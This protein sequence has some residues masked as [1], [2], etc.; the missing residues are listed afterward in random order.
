[1]G[2]PELLR[3][4][5]LPVGDLIFNTSFSRN[6][7]QVRSLN[8]KNHQELVNIQEH[9]LKNLLEYATENSG[10]YG[11]LNI[12]EEE[13]PFEWVKKFPIL[14]K[15]ILRENTNQLLTCSM[16]KLKSLSSSGSSG[17]QSTVYLNNRELSMFWANQIN[18]W[19]WGG[20]RIGDSMIQMGVNPK[21]GIL[22]GLKDRFFK[23][24]YINSFS[25]TE[26]EIVDVLTTAK[27]NK[28]RFLC[29]YSS[30]LNL[31]ALIAKKYNIS[32]FYFEGVISLGEM[33][34]KPYRENIKA[35]FQCSVFETYGSGEG[36]LIASQKDI[37][38]L[39]INIPHVYLELLDEQGNE[40]PDGEPGHVVVTSL[41]HFSMPL[42]RY[43]LGDMA[44]KLP[45]EKYPT[46]RK[47]DMP[48]LHQVLGRNTDVI[49]TPS[50]KYLTVHSFTGLFAKYSQIRQFK[51]IR[52][53]Y[54]KLVIEFVRDKNFHKEIPAHLKEKILQEI[55]NEFDIVFTEVERIK[56]LNSGKLQIIE[57]LY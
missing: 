1:M 2:Y 52:K 4:I 10:Y 9:R 22:R 45:K 34:T 29:G 5:L 53:D 38:S 55:T 49:K 41:I 44:V 18:W 11:S 17:Y 33:M 7:R 28:I 36:L 6:L 50:G 42:I 8:N 48:L 23:V 51:I 46:H 26:D 12:E 35:V 13:N 15:K 32:G 16:N 14:N 19:E 56:P 21:R 43:K 24:I 20:Y 39:Y 57:D 27:R 40:V 54:T 47:L 37:D 31:F 3:K 25:L 30:A